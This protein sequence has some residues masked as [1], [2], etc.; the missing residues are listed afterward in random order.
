M[1]ALVTSSKVILLITLGIP[2]LLALIALGALL[3]RPKR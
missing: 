3:T 1:I 2:T